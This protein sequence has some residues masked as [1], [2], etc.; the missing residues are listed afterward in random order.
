MASGHCV[1]LQARP[2]ATHCAVQKRGLLQGAALIVSLDVSLVKLMARPV[3]IHVLN[4]TLLLN[5]LHIFRAS[6]EIKGRYVRTGKVRRGSSS[7]LVVP[8]VR[9][10]G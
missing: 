10:Q 6:S 2:P 9:L 8:L 7:V 5:G 1:R 4:R 3:N